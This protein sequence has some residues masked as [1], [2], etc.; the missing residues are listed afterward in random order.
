MELTTID[1][2]YPLRP[3]LRGAGVTPD[4]TAQLVTDRVVD[5]NSPQAMK[6]H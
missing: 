6:Q 4:G 2:P 1:E 3:R 5:A